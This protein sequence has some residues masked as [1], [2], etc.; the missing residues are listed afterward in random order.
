MSEIRCGEP[1]CGELANT[2]SVVEMANLTGGMMAGLFRNR[3]SYQCPAGHV[4]NR[5]SVLTRF[6]EWLRG[7]RHS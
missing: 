3:R 1:D 7:T 6:R 5:A 4:T 2:E